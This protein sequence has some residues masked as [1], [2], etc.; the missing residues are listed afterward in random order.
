M[1]SIRPWGI[2]SDQLQKR[3]MKYGMN[4]KIFAIICVLDVQM[5][6]ASSF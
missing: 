2:T 4:Y 6:D 3:N 5:G 1:L